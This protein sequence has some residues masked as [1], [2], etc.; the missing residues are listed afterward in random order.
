LRKHPSHTALLLE[1]NMFFFTLRKISFF[2]EKYLTF[3]VEKLSFHFPTEL[4]LDPDTRCRANVMWRAGGP[5]CGFLAVL[6]T[7]T[8]SY[9]ATA[10]GDAAVD[11]LLAGPASVHSVSPP[12][13]YPPSLATRYA[14]KPPSAFYFLPSILVIEAQAQAPN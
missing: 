13:R 14:A 4:I 8:L 5:A 12:S 9:A 1:K 11:G 10:P 7:V 6:I 2:Q 3:S